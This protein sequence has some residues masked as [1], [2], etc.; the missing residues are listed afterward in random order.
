MKQ[1]IF[2]FMFVQEKYN[3]ITWHRVSSGAQETARAE[4]SWIGEEAGSPGVCAGASMSGVVE[5]ASGERFIGSLNR[6]NRDLGS[7]S[8]TLCGGMKATQEAWNGV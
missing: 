7:E 4:H 8:H 3:N 1:V 6:G 2:H 5:K